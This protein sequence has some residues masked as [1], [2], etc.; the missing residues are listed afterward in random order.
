MSLAR[1]KTQK[2]KL[3]NITVMKNK[4]VILTLLSVAA[5]AVGCN[6]AETASD[7]LDA[8]Q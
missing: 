2:R 4:T 7:K 3:K 1:P 8:V 6:K 5:F